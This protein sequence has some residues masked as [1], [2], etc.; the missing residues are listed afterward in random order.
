MKLFV[1]WIVKVVYKCELLVAVV[2][3]VLNIWLRINRCRKLSVGNMDFFFLNP[4]ERKP[5]RDTFI[6]ARLPLALAVRLRRIDS[7]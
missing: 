7:S 1:P 5:R 6:H 4:I 2:E 3:V